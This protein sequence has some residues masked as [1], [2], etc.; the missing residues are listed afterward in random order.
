MV[1]GNAC[2]AFAARPHQLIDRPEPLADL[3]DLPQNL[4]MDALSALLRVVKLSG[5]LFYNSR[6]SAPWCMNAPPSIMLQPY[7]TP[8]ATHIIEFHYISEGTAYVRVGE[9][10]TPLSAGDIVMIPHGDAHIMGAGVGGALLDGKK[11]L[12]AMIA[13]ELHQSDFGGGGANTGLVCGYLACDGALIKPILAG[14]P[15]VL[16]VNICAD[17]AGEWLEK[18]LR[19][20]VEQAAN[21]TPGSDVILAHLAEVLFAEV[22]R[23]YLLSLPEG[24]TGWLAG[25]GDPA[26]GRALAVLHHR[27]ADCWTLDAL[28]KEA[29]VSRSAL[30]EKF[31]CLLGQS[32][33]SYLADWR[34]E[35]GAEALRTTS[36]SVQRVANDA[37]YESE[38][39]FNRAFKRRFSVPPARYRREARAAAK[40]PLEPARRMAQRA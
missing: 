11:A 17:P 5:A 29:G 34:L 3:I 20:A 32:P 2:G 26:V 7:V 18:T 33:M 6:C 37:G 14:L 35:L 39:A 36:R 24:R 1:L 38:A 4:L 9:E 8:G 21:C 28:A 10:T 40:I 22:L 31:T 15:R 25:A 12:P 30:T 13:G 19:H 16:R 27:P 23:R